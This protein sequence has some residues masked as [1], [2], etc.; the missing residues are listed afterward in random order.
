MSIN[1]IEDFIDKRNQTSGLKTKEAGN[2][3]QLTTVSVTR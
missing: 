3:S 2:S 1:K